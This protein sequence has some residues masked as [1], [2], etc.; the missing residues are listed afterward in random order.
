[1]TVEP[2]KLKGGEGNAQQAEEHLRIYRR[3][4]AL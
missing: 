4:T 2:E 3:G 1:M